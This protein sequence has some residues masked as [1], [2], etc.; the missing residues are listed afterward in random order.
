MALMSVEK[1]RAAEEANRRGLGLAQTGKI[2]VAVAEFEEAV[3]LNPEHALARFNLGLCWQQLGKD[4]WAEREYKEVVKIDSRVTGAYINLAA[5]YQS[6]GQLKKAE[7]V[8]EGVVEVGG[9]SGQVLMALGMIKKQLGDN[10]GAA[11]CFGERAKIDGGNW[12]VWSRLGAAWLAEGEFDRAGRALGKAVALD[13]GETEIWNDLGRLEMERFEYKKALG[14]FER[15]VSLDKGFIEALNNQGLALKGL[16]RHREAERVFGRVVKLKPD[17]VEAYYHW[18]LE[19]EELRE[20]PE[21]AERYREAMKLL[22]DFSEACSGLCSVLTTMC[23]WEELGRWKEVEVELAWKEAKEGKRL[24]LAPFYCVLRYDNPRLNLVSAKSWSDQMEEKMAKLAGLKR[25]ARDKN[26]KK[27]RLGYVSHDFYHHPVAQLAAGVYKR[28]D[29]DIFEVYVYS[30]APEMVKDYYQERVK[31]E[32][33][34]YVDIREL[35]FKEGAQRMV[36]DGVDIAI[37]L[38][39]YTK[40]NRME[41]FALRPAPVQVTWLGYPG[42]SGAGF[43]DYLIGDGVVV[44]RDQRQYYSE[45]I[46]EMPGCYQVNDCEQPVFEK[47]LAR[48]EFGLPEK[49]VVLAAFNQAYK[50]DGPMYATWMRIMKR[51]PGSVLWLLYQDKVAMENL[52]EAAKEAGMAEAR[53]VFAKSVVKPAHLERL[54]LADLA[55]DTRIVNGHTSTSDA[56]W[57]GVPV[58]TLQGKHFASRVAASILRADGLEG[59]VTGSLAEYEE[60]VVGLCKDRKRLA[61]LKKKMVANKRRGELFD[62]DLFVERLERAYELVWERYKGGERPRHVEA[63]EFDGY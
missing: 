20:L 39:G 6:R 60:L 41:M 29:R 42:T 30:F 49:G 4:K 63:V 48:Q 27:I 2:E 36:D 5:I 16:G 33:D 12:Q 18:G 52:R 1:M 62:T 9:G 57:A 50:I 43:F 55:L 47:G 17:Y 32:A 26:R 56:L 46:I 14:H 10:K 24:G 34:C 61:R 37:D 3:K 19:L 8:L 51:V 35:G 38:M 7:R 15:A 58:V 25:R 21:A 23:E 40:H 11:K 28:H 59:L 44:P 13:A 45:S 53:L 31:G 54:R 22:E